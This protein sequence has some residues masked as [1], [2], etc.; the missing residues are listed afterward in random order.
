VIHRPRV[1]IH[2]CTQ[3]RWL[4]RAAWY[5]QELL[6]TFE[7]ELVGRL[8][9]KLERATSTLAIKGFWLEDPALAD[10]PAFGAALARGLAHF[11]HF[12]GAQHINTVAIGM[13]VVREQIC[14]TDDEFAS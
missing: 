4:L 8:D 9:P 2:Y 10:D 13:E 7:T 6:T 1:Q 3:C 14:T 5:A 12:V 11:A